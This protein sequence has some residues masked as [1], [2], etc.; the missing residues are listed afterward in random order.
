MTLEITD[1]HKDQFARDGYFRHSWVGHYIPRSFNP[2]PYENA[3]RLR[4]SFD[5]VCRFT[6]TH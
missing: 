3:P 5:G 1:A 6:P 4:V 2:W